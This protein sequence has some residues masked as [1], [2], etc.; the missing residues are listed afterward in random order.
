MSEVDVKEAL[1]RAVE[2]CCVHAIEMFPPEAIRSWRIVD[3]HT[4]L[5][6][7]VIYSCYE[8]IPILAKYIDVNTRNE[9]GETALDMAARNGK[10][11]AVE[12]LL[13]AG[14]D[15]TALSKRNGET[16]L[17]TAVYN[18]HIDVVRLL[19]SRGVSPNARNGEAQRGLKLRKESRHLDTV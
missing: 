16:P 10:L 7:A 17:H 18:R 6:M 19:L 1:D 15:P 9:L 12:L 3:G 13:D 14:A 11:E 2:Q 5:H 8:A 4:L